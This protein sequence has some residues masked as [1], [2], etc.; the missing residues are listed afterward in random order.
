[1][2]ITTDAG[3]SVVPAY[4]PGSLATFSSW[5]DAAATGPANNQPPAVSFNI[6][7]G[8]GQYDFSSSSYF[9][10]TSWS[11]DYF[12]FSRSGSTT[13]QKEQVNVDTSSASFNVN[14]TFQALTTVTIDP[15]PWFDSSLMYNYPNSSGLV[16]PISLIIGMMPTVKVTFDAASYQS[17]QSSY[18]SSSSFGV[19]IFGISV[20]GNG[21]SSTGSSFKSQWDATALTL[22][23]SDESTQP[24]IIGLQVLEALGLVSM[25]LS[26]VP[27]GG[28]GLHPFPRIGARCSSLSRR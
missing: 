24:K 9:S 26:L 17:A 13:T 21:S 19:G 16:R 10:R 28:E 3:S 18:S 23:I 5:V 12:F 4:E 15:G 11:E 25:L 14:I 2:L 22:T 1:M 20:G 6:C 27:S 8:A 7:Q